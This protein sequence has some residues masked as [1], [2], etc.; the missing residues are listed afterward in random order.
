MK[1]RKLKKEDAPLMHQWMQ[2]DNVTHYLRADFASKTE[3]D[4]ED[5]IAA[6]QDE[7]SNLHLAVVDDDDTY[8][9][10]VSLKNI[11]DGKAEFA[12]TVRAEAM[13]KGYASFGMNEIIRKGFDELGLE[14][15]FWNVLKDNHRA[16]SFYDKNG[17]KQVPLKPEFLVGG[18]IPKKDF[19][20][21]FG[22]RLQERPHEITRKENSTSSKYYCLGTTE[23]RKAFPSGTKGNC[24]KIQIS[25]EK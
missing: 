25:E 7:T 4:C 12:I 11:S 21:S 16:I 17:Y 9:G 18:G 22:I 1:L 5:F 20:D 24:I 6:A 2:D 23:Y 14:S 8:M 10:T 15:I 19:K 13:G 3:T